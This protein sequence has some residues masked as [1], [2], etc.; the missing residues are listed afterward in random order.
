MLLS[1]NKISFIEHNGIQIFPQQNKFKEKYSD[2]NI[3]IIY[4]CHETFS[5][6]IL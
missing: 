4:F 3:N 6:D 1:Q 2:L 5:I